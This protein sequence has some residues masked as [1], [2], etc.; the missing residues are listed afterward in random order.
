MNYQY[1]ELPYKLMNYCSD[2]NFYINHYTYH[3][4]ETILYC[5]PKEKF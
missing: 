4:S 2:Y 5:V 1:V 3:R